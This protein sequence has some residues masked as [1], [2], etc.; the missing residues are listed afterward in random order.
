MNEEKAREILKDVITDNNCLAGTYA[1]S[2][3]CGNDNI[4][5][6]GTFTLDELEAMAWWVRNKDITP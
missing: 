1:Y 3:W 5:L 4:T 2:D 6:D